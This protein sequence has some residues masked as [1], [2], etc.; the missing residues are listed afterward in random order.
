MLQVGLM[1]GSLQSQVH[2][3]VGVGGALLLLLVISALT[4]AVMVAR[5][6]TQIGTFAR[7]VVVIS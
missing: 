1:L 3:V 6:H 4:L 7:W 5:I 2:V